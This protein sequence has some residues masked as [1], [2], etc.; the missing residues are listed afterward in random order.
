MV[1]NPS[2][3]AGDVGEA[4]SIPGSERTAGG[5]NT[6]QHSCLGNSMDR[7]ACWAMAHGISKEVDTT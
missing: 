3:C 4:G 2:A 6:L 5:G 7:G 1:K